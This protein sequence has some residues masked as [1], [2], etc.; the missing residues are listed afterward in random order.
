M[1][2]IEFKNVSYVYANTSE[3]AVRNI[4]LTVHAG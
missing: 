2:M 4:S 3:E 1:P